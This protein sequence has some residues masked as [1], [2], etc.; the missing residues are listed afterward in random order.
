MTKEEL[1]QKYNINKSHSVWDEVNDSWYSVEIY[2]LLH[3]KLPNQSNINNEKITWILDFFNKKDDKEWWMKNVMIK[4]DWGSYY[5]TAKRMIYIY[6][7]YIIE[8]LNKT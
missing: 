4:P 3:N 5:L 1:F 8:E 2:K 7:D 6:A